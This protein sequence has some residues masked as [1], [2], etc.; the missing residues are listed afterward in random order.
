MEEP[1]GAAMHQLAAPVVNVVQL[2]RRG[3]CYAVS[4]FFA[5]F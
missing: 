4:R 2:S 5:H 3:E 1:E